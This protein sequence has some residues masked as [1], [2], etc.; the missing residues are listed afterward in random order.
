MKG[1]AGN[2]RVKRVLRSKVA[3]AE[4]KIAN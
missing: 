1:R 4:K 3:R 2:K